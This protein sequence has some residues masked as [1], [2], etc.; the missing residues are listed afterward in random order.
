[1]SV[2][3]LSRCNPHADIWNRPGDNVLWKDEDQKR[4]AV[5]QSV[6][7]S[8]RTATVRFS[9]SGS[10]ELASVLELDPHGTTDWSGMSPNEGL[11]VSRGEFVFI[12]PEGTTNGATSPFVPRIGEVESWVRDTTGFNGGPGGWRREVVTL[13]NQIATRRGTDPSVEE[14]KI[15]RPQPEDSSLN[16]FGEVIDVCTLYV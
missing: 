12:H 1:M 4:A 10:T 15:K 11:G 14:G 5:V 9:D 3:V 6:N 2:T 7:A 16:W 13:G 8:D